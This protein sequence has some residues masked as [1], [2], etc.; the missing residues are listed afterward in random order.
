MK[1]T[2][3]NF[4]SKRTAM[5]TYFK[6]MMCFAAAVITLAACNTVET[7]QPVSEEG[8][9]YTFTLGSPETRAL[10]ASDEN[11]KFGAWEKGDQLGSAVN[12]G[13]LGYSNIETT[14]SPMTFKIY[15]SG[16]LKE[17][18]VVYTYYPYS[19]E[20]T[21]TSSI[22]FTIPV[23]QSQDGTSFDFDAMPM[24]GEGFVVPVSLESESST[25]PVGD[26]S[27][28]NLGSVIDYQ[29]YSTNS[30]LAEETI[31]SVSLTANKAVAGAFTKDITSV[32]NNDESTLTIAGYSETTVTTSVV[33]PATIGATRS[34]ASHVYMVIAPVDGESETGITGTVLVT[35]NKAKY[36]FNINTAQKF[37]RAGLKSFGLNLAT[38]QNRVEEAAAVPTYYKLDDYYQ[39]NDKVNPLELDDVVTLTTTPN[40]N[41]GKFFGNEPNR[42]WRL[43]QS[44]EAFVTV[45]VPIGYELRSI[46]FIYGTSNGG[47]LEGAPS[48]EVLN[49]SGQ[50]QTYNVVNTGSVTNGQVR[51]TAITVSYVTVPVPEG[52]QLMTRVADIESGLYVIAAKV[53]DKYYAMSNSFG[54][55]IDGTE[56]TV[57][58]GIISSSAAVNYVVTITKNDSNYLIEG[59]DNISL[60]YPSNGTDFNLEGTNTNWTIATG[61]NGTFRIANANITSRAIAFNGSRF[62]AYSTS[63]ITSGSISYYDVELF[64]FNGTPKTIPTT[65]VTP[66]SPI[67]LE[68]G[69]TQQLTVTTNSDGAKSYESSADAIAT[70]TDAGL[71]TALAAGT[72]TITIKTAA[73][74]TFSEGM[75]TVTVEVSDPNVPELS[76]S[77][78]TSAASPASWPADN[79]DTKTFTIIPTNGTWSFDASDVSS[80]ANV[81]RSNDVLNVTPKEKRAGEAHSGSIVITLTP[82]NNDYE[83]V[84]AT[85]YLAQAKYSGGGTYSLTPNAASTGNSSTSYITTLTEFTYNGISWKM[86]QWN[87]STLQIKTNQGSAANEFRFYNTSAFSGRITKVVIKFSALTVSDASMLM[88]L[89]GTSEVTTTSGGTAGTWDD[90]AKTLTWTPGSSDNFTYFAFYQNGKAASG[91]NFLADSD[92]IVVTYN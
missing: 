18:D 73:T 74:E 36:T 21:S 14:T 4:N 80:W 5:K 77:P 66:A 81:T 88:F 28:V 37:K 3:V 91:T 48:G 27:L 9:Y 63:N 65:T 68:V 17:N 85:I 23:S 26:I 51:L 75:T 86:N 72:A 44:E 61:I 1:K 57:S 54:S 90:S 32:K 45:S 62:G 52:Y 58:D 56:I 71:I 87:P 60:G 41:S 78:S 13:A 76:V 33:A 43:Y 15:K 7:E 64:K 35:T 25:T 39:A 34:A 79:N 10:L 24:V 69:D 22:P 19:S 49:V 42:D 92:A 29:I 40:G 8:Y 55:K 89:G 82:S 59:S 6:S 12:E 67:N 16:G 53:G 11:G 70:V 46:E 20:A 50:S 30:E 84:S 2:V 83:S 47:T 31:V 38:C